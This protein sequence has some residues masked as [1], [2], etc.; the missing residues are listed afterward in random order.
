[1]TGPG[2]G[3]VKTITPLK[4]PKAVGCARSGDH[5]VQVVVLQGEVSTMGFGPVALGLTYT[6][7]TNIE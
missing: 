2:R 3:T 6:V 5:V 1:M 7:V 4:A